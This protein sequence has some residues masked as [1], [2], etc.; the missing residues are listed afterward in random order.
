MTDLKTVL[1][2]VADLPPERLFQIGQ[3]IY[4]SVYCQGQARGT[5]KAHD[6]QTVKFFQDRYE[7]AFS[8][9]ADRRTRGPDDPMCPRRI[10]RVRWIEHVIAG[11]ADKWEC[12]EQ[13]RQG[14][15]K[16][17]Y[18]VPGE[19]YIVWLEAARE[20]RVWTFSTAYVV[21]SDTLFARYRAESRFVASG[22]KNAP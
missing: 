9:S 14:R 7:H 22:K 4:E 1:V 21:D 12:R 8:K 11:K 18:F 20:P 5:L 3:Q 19:N 17:L 15:K 16:R 10:A 6:G 2:T 13:E